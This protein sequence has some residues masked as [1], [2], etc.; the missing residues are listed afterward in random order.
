M[1]HSNEHSGSQ[2][3]DSALAKR[4]QLQL[5]INAASPFT[6]LDPVAGQK[7]ARELSGEWQLM[8][9]RTRAP[10]TSAANKVDANLYRGV[11]NKKPGLRPQGM[12]NS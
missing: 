4:E 6:K 10:N 8:A 12:K 11:G 5:A 7:P 3:T 2:R 9:D 1:Q